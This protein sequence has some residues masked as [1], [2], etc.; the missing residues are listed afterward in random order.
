MVTAVHE[1]TV[2][3]ELLRRLACGDSALE[4]L[5][6]D[7]ARLAQPPD[8]APV[9]TLLAALAYL[10]GDGVVVAAALDRALVSD[11][12]YSLAHL[13]DD[14]LHLQLEPRDLRTAWA[15]DLA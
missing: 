4:L 14:S 8:D 1:M 10:R 6:R 12:D 11:P 3:D 9:A 13:M 2:R 5:I 7:V 15:G